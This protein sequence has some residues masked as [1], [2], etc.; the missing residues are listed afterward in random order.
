MRMMINRAMFEQIDR[1]NGSISVLSAVIHR[2]METGSYS[3]IAVKGGREVASFIIVVKEDPSPDPCEDIG[4]PAFAIFGEG[5]SSLTTI[6]LRELESSSVGFA[7]IERPFV[8]GK[9]GSALFYVPKGQ[10]GYSIKVCKMD[11]ERKVVLDSEVLDRDDAF[12]TVCLR[13]GT[14][15]VRNEITKAE[16]RLV[17]PYPRV[18][19]GPKQPKPLEVECGKRSFRPKEIHTTTLQPLLFR[20]TTPSRIT[21]KLKEPDDGQGS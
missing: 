6:D 7:M 3:G 5:P 8:V 19:V 12:L 18:G 17:V 11:G 21:I 20:F 15:A 2:F 13:P 1:D 14:Y 9:G 10:G 4:N 16:A